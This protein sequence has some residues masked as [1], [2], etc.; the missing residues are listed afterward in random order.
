MKI[1][2][3]NKEIRNENILKA[4][5]VET[6]LL[7]R[8]DNGTFGG[9]EEELETTDKSEK[10][11][12]MC[13]FII[14]PLSPKSIIDPTKIE[15]SIEEFRFSGRQY[16]K[17]PVSYIEKIP[18]GI[19]GYEYYLKK[20]VVEFQQ[21][22][23]NGLLYLSYDLLRIRD[24]RKEI[25]IHTITDNLFIFLKIAKKFYSIAEFE[26]SLVGNISL[27]NVEEVITHSILPS[28][29]QWASKK[30]CLLPKYEWKIEIDTKIL[31]DDKETQKYF[32]EKVKEIYWSLGHELAKDQL[33]EDY[34][35]EQGWLVE[36]I[37]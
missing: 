11:R 37:Q 2:E 4:K 25:W 29:Y 7:K 27:D 31:N 6:A 32:L 30:I 13:C 10:E 28:R 8:A 9:D 36:F 24:D 35:K 20:G 34:L 33:Y 14:Q 18:S 23:S 5:E 12:S 21:M 15:N 26:G 1:D 22:Y 16:G 19:L 3:K 17:F